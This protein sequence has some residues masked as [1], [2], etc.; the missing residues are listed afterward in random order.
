MSSIV[1]EKE[2]TD[3][4]ITEDM[5]EQLRK[6]LEKSFIKNID[7]CVRCDFY[8]DSEGIYRPVV[9]PK[10]KSFILLDNVIACKY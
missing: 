4:V 9:H 3:I 7:G 10:G 5:L 2:N 6:T 8:K 1:T